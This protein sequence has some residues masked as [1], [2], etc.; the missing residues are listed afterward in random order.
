MKQPWEFSW[1]ALAF[2]RRRLHPGVLS[3]I[4]RQNVVACA[5]LQQLLFWR[6]I[7]LKK[8]II[9]YQLKNRHKFWRLNLFLA[10]SKKMLENCVYT[11]FWLRFLLLQ[12]CY[13]KYFYKLKNIL[14]SCNLCWVIEN[15]LFIFSNLKFRTYLIDKWKSDK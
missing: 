5:S 6:T 7:F 11:I 4:L 1:I 15:N 10:H 9:F 3:W 8:I 13:E 2:H 14:S 12:C